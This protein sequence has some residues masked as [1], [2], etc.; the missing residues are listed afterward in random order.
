MRAVDLSI[1]TF[2]PD[3]ALLQQLLDSLAEPAAAPLERNV[4]IHDNSGDARL[5]E[6]IRTLPQLSDASRFDRVE[7]HASESNVGFGRGHNANAARAPSPFFFVLNQDCVLEPGVLE[8]A[9][10]TALAA[11]RD[12]AAWELRQIPYEH[13]KSY[14]PVS[15]ETGWVSGAATLLRREAFDA[16]G[17][18]EPRIFMYGEDVDLSWRLRAN[19]WRL[20]YQPRLAC[21]HRT[22]RE[23]GEVKPLQVFGG[24]ATNLCLRARFGGRLATLR[25]LAMLGGE[26]LAPGSF[27]GR[28]RGLVRAGM[29]F[30][31]QW[32]YFARSRVR[33]TADFHPVFSGWG[34]ELRREGAFVPMR[35]RREA[36]ARGEPLVSIL[37]RT[38][39][40]PSWLREA[41]ASCANQTYANLEVVVVEDGPE[42]SR[43]IVESFGDRLRIRYHATGQ[44]VG[45]ARAG[46]LALEQARGE[47]LN[48]L[49]DD[50]VLFAD[51]VEVL[52]EAATRSRAAGAYALA[53]E[54]YTDV[55]RDSGRY[56]EVL[57]ITRHH[58]PFDRLTL[59]HHNYL[60]IQAVLFHRRLYERHG[61]F[62]EDMDQLEDWNLWTRYTLEDALVMVA[63][64]TS[65]YRVPSDMRLAAGRQ[66]LLDRAYAEALERQRR[67]QVTF[68]PREI[69]EMAEAYAR[70]QTVVMVTRGDL[71][72]LVR[73]SRVMSRIASYRPL[74]GRMLRRLGWLK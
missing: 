42:N 60:P 20:T 38:V 51:H 19:G 10:D 47:W 18:F 62:A 53:W 35:S 52:V 8:R 73:A 11:P 33:P 74:A 12:I 43:G 64:T 15:L 57:H 31:S 45:R 39:D 5:L 1:V 23:A 66:A 6:R 26:I 55:D 14:D 30:L 41:L 13:P 40:R 36:G 27:P 46:N 16:V 3:L 2:Q 70:R 67:M 69:S 7:I 44:P 29:R 17:G 68:S 9:V 72:R 71:R 25:G 24:V 22:Y 32:P 61:G 28:R 56:R 49:D 21:V 59:W 37:I 63:K 48:F 54:T 58:Q 50:D 34:Y 4:F 65:K